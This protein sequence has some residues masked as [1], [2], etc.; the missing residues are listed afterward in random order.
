MVIDCS[1]FFDAIRKKKNEYWLAGM[2]LILDISTESKYKI[3]NKLLKND[4]V[5]DF[6]VERLYGGGNV[7]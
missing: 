7:S 2:I 6:F 4:E 1:M 3:G 5:F